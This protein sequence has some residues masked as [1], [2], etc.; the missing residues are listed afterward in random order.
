MTRVLL[1]LLTRIRLPGS[2]ADLEDAASQQHLF[3]LVGLLVGLMATL[4][5]IVFGSLFSP[6]D[7]LIAGSL[8]IAALYAITGIIHTEGLADFADGAMAN[9]SRDR[10]LAVMKDPHAGVAAVIVV[11]VFLLV[12]LALASEMCARARESI[13]PFPIVWNAPVVFGFV[14]S[15]VS[16][17]LAMNTSMLIGPSA[18]HGMGSAFVN[19][20]SSRKFAVAIALAFGPCALLI[21]VASMILLVGI[22][23]GGAV[24]IAA[25]KH[26]GGVSGDVFGAANEIGRVGTLILWVLII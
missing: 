11:I 14:V 6:E 7:N 10:K 12:F 19:R 22:V 21:G 15:E 4:V 5:C 18:H 25:R 24:T 8:M 17:K 2:S 3:P 13:G 16:G 26:F 1:G 20:A 23:A 9:G